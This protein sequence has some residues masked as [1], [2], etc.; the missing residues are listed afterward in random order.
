MPRSGAGM[1]PSV[2][3]DG[4]GLSE[5]ERFLRTVPRQRRSID[6]L[7]RLLNAV[8]EVL[9]RSGVDGLSMT[10]VAETSGVPLA[11][12]YD[13]F[14]DT[15]S[16]VGAFSARGRHD[17][18][19]AV[20][21]IIGP[22]MTAA[23]ITVRLTSALDYF[24]DMIRTEP[25]FR[26]ADAICDG[27]PDLHAFRLEAAKLYADF[28]TDLILPHAPPESVHKV[29]PRAKLASYL[30]TSLGRYV[31]TLEPDEARLMIDTY[32]E[33]FLEPLSD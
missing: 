13:Y 31:V 29:A 32:V 15:K 26:H 18:F 33:M 30:V 7:E 17:A 28:L 2:V 25:G 9:E 20:V 12:I 8:G 11:S 21:D 6:R 5:M 1:V 14:G 23:N 19:N 3:L 27:D 10:A 4:Q 22:D 24:V 16:M